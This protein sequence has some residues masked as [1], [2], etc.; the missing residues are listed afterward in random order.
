MGTWTCPCVSRFDSS[1]PHIHILQSVW[2]RV[3]V[4][5]DAADYIS[6][7]N[8]K[9]VTGRGLVMSS[10]SPLTPVLGTHLRLYMVVMSPRLLLPYGHR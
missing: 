6:I 9:N 2:G 8:T 10:D 3:I 5:S 4:S 7:H 1:N